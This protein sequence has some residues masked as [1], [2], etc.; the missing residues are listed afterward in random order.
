MQVALP[1]YAPDIRYAEIL[2][3]YAEALNEVQGTY[4]IP[5]WNGEKMHTI[6]RKTEELKKGVQP[7]RIR[8]GLPD[9]ECV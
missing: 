5:S 4:E 3:N 1:K 6:T 2:L 7:I 8:A 9:Y